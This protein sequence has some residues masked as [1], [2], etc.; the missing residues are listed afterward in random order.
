MVACFRSR[1][2]S[3]ARLLLQRPGGV[4]EMANSYTSKR[5][6]LFIY[7]NSEQLIDIQDVVM[8]KFDM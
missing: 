3:T 2:V 1:N 4:L 7:K 5:I 8:H 6:Q